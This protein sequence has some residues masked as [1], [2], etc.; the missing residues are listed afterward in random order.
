MFESILSF[1]QGQ[2]ISRR[3]KRDHPVLDYLIVGGGPAGLYCAK[4]IEEESAARPNIRLIER[5]RVLGG[6]TRME[7]FHSKL[8]NTGAGVGR[9]KKD[10]ILKDLVSQ[11][12]PSIPS[13]SANICHDFA[14]PVNTLDVIAELKTKKKDISR[15]RH[16]KTFKQF[17][18]SH[19]SFSF[20]RRFCL[21]NGYTDFENADIVDT[22][23]N[24]GFED[25]VSGAMFF[26]V[27]W[28]KLIRSLKSCLHHTKISV[29]REMVSYT[30]DKEEGTWCVRVR[31]TSSFKE[32]ILYTRRLVFAGFLE[33]KISRK[34]F[35]NQIGTHPFLR[36]YT[37]TKAYSTFPKECSMIFRPDIFQK[38]LPISRHIQMISYSDNEHAIASRKYFKDLEEK[39]A[40][41]TTRHFFWE[42]GTHY[43][44][45]L[46]KQWK[47]R[48]D[49]IRHAQNPVQGLFVVGEIV[50]NN[51]G[52]TEGAFESVD[53]ILPKLLL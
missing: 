2:G 41:C 52:W 18:L 39:D 1:F 43:Y 49:F 37:Y 35:R 31:S 27:P 30:F 5:N 26:R 21:S 20:Y 22:L 42:A 9:T 8:V 15:Y 7:S 47:T 16:T 19:F 11:I 23:Y 50:S 33:K 32:E 40:D 48:D 4:R 51:Q 44:R 25:N 3:S 53:A 13:F 14:D 36:A 46:D 28:N 17:F 10:K 34:Y 38:T 24:Y 12:V 29:G 45:P 6:R